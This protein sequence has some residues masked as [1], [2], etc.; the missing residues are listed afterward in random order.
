MI[1][2]DVITEKEQTC[3]R[4]QIRIQL[5]PAA[6]TRYSTTSPLNGAAKEWVDPPVIVPP[7]VVVPLAGLNHSTFST[8]V[9]AARFTV[10]VPPFGAYTKY[11]APL[12][13]LSARQ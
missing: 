13:T 7:V 3:N 5:W 12:A 1:G 4:R 6:S 11:S 10:K 2:G 8:L 9:V